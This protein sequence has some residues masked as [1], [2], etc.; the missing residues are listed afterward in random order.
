MVHVT[1]VFNP[2]LRSA[3][4]RHSVSV[5]SF[6]SWL[7]TGDCFFVLFLQETTL[8]ALVHTTW[9]GHHWKLCIQWLILPQQSNI[10]IY[11]YISIMIICNVLCYHGNKTCLE[12]IYLVMRAHFYIQKGMMRLNHSKSCRKWGTWQLGFEIKRLNTSLL[13]KWSA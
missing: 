1:P 5:L 7:Y 12:I 3:T 2:K 4:Y 10:Y 6:V 11:I 9:I 8:G 13:A